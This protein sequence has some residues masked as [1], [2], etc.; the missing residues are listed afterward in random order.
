MATTTFPS[1]I[2]ENVQKRAD[3]PFG[4]SFLRVTFT[5]DSEFPIDG[6][7]STSS[8]EETS[9]DGTSRLDPVYDDDHHQDL[10]EQDLL[11]Y[12]FGMGTLTGVL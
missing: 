3:A 8:N 12:L 11:C 6:K 9:N 7:N 2:L 10:D 1:A 5:Q 4:I